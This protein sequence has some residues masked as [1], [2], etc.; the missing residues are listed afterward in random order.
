MASNMKVRESIVGVSQQDAAGLWHYHFMQGTGT[1]D[2]AARDAL[3]NLRN[4]PAWF[5]FNDTP[6]PINE[7]DTVATLVRRYFHWR[8]NIQSD[9]VWLLKALHSLTPGRKSDAPRERFWLSVCGLPWQEATQEQYIEAE[10]SCGFYPNRGCGPFATS[11]FGARG[12]QGRRT[13]GQID[14]SMGYDP[15]FVAIANRK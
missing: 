4:Y 13:Y 5:W 14:A 12:I 2:L 7:G 15:E 6:C 10:R 1:V 9:P 11:S 8:K 3:D